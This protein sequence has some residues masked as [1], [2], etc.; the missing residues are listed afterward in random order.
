MS[1]SIL[2]VPLALAS[3]EPSAQPAP[4]PAPSEPIVQ[5]VQVEDRPVHEDVPPTVYEPPVP[6]PPVPLKPDERAALLFALGFGSS[7]GDIDKAFPWGFNVGFAGSVRVAKP[8]HATVGVQFSVLHL[9]DAG[10]TGYIVCD[11]YSC[12][13]ETESGTLVALPLGLSLHV[14]IADHRI[15]FGA[16]G[17]YAWYSASTFQHTGVRSGPGVFGRVT[18]SIPGYRSLYYELFSE[19]SLIFS[20]GERF[21]GRIDST[22]ST[23]FWLNFG[24]AIRFLL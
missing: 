2:A 3:A 17:Q 24:L 22:S 23:D 18:W 7:F 16:G 14:P 1:L 12:G 15:L 9:R 6:P 19:G 21:V 13:Q 20:E 4:Q 11:G 5:Q 10:S 8:L